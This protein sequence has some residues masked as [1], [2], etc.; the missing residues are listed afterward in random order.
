MTLR[1]IFSGVL[2]AAVLAC[3]I[4]AQ[5]PEPTRTATIA[6]QQA[7]KAQVLQPYEPT[8]AERIFLKI[9]K[10]FI[11]TPSGF[12]PLT[13]TVYK[14]TGFALGGGYR[15]YA[16]DRTFLDAKGLL[17]YENSK[18]GELSL[19][20]PDHFARK[21]D[22]DVTAGFRHV[23]HVEFFGIGQ[24]PNPPQDQIPFDE[25]YG[26]GGAQFRPVWPMVLGLRADY[27][28]YQFPTNGSNPAYL[29]LTEAAGI[30]WRP[31]AGYARR[32]GLYEVRYHQYNDRGNAFSFNRG[33]AE[34]VQHIPILREN[35]IISMHGLVDSVL[36]N[37]AP[38]PFLLLPAL[39]GSDSLRGYPSWRFRDLNSLLLQG[40]FRW[41]PNQYGLDMALF[42]DTGKVA[43][44]RSDLNLH[45]LKSDV[46]AEVRFHGPAQTPLRFGVARG[47]EGWHVIFAASAAF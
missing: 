18:L 2:V 19:N 30:D 3:P 21:V 27:E 32:G 31:S 26:G 29:H 22:F 1:R 11:D 41:T 9:K 23:S 39:G 28:S 44:N 13:G 46:G 47:S 8:T 17:S 20:S 43:N 25:S 36:K 24:Q 4:A 14:G 42:Y 37:D 5:S 33:E 34:I 10:E 15:Y 7:E 12:Y 6:D 16:H 45:A 35:W 40:E 38:I